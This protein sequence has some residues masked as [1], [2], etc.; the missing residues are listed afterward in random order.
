MT[1]RAPLA[2]R[3]RAYPKWPGALF[4]AT[5]K[6]DGKPAFLFYGDHKDLG[7]RQDVKDTVV[8][9]REAANAFTTV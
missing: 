6:R 3:S 7:L 5:L 8:L 4:V 2:Y 9:L 1:A